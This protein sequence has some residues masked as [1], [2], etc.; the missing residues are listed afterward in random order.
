MSVTVDVAVQEG[1]LGMPRSLAVAAATAAL[2]S[3]RVRNAALS[4]AFV[5]N[6]TIARINREHLGRRGSTDVIAFGFLPSGPDA[7]LVGDVYIATDVARR[8]ARERGIPLREELVRLVV[9]GTLHVMG[10]DHPESE[11]RLRAPMWAL[12]E[13]LVA[14]VLTAARA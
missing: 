11:E 9:H 10:H 7:P 1:R 8:A 4:I 3:G 6:R 12:Q 5:S 14:R 2:R 13:R